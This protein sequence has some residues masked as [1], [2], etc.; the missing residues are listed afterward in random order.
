MIQ[1]YQ[2]SLMDLD[3]PQS[4]RKEARDFLVQCL[5]QFLGATIES[6]ALEHLPSGRPVLRNH[7][8]LSFSLSHSDTAV[9][10]ACSRIFNVGIDIQH[11]SPF[12]ENLFKRICAPQE[13]QKITQKDAQSFYYFWTIKEAAMKCIGLGFQYPMNKIEID[14]STGKI[15]LLEKK[16]YSMALNYHWDHLEFAEFKAPANFRGHVVWAVHPEHA[17]YKANFS[18]RA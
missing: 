18:L 1:V 15:H 9:A 17:N 13:L 5:A 6:L 12:N 14:S 4:F 3:D 16:E 11:V 8:D 2:K 10:V 7:P